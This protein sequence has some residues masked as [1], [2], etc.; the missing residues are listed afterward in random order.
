MD[1]DQSPG[2][3]EERAVQQHRQTQLWLDRTS[4]VRDEWR[5][6]SSSRTRQRQQVFLDASAL[7]AAPLSALGS[8]PRLSSWPLAGLPIPYALLNRKVIAAEPCCTAQLSNTH[9]LLQHR[10]VS[11]Q[12]SHCLQ[13]CASLLEYPQDTQSHCPIREQEPRAG[14][15]RAAYPGG[16]ES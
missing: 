1:T 8:L 16:R 5:S 9:P 11:Q 13:G 15:G 6:V 2:P 14:G 3:K 10:A 4:C 7:P 12:L